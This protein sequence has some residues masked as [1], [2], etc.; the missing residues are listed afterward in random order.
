[1]ERR[2]PPQTEEG[3]YAL[4]DFRRIDWDAWRSVPDRTRERTLRTGIEYRR[5][6]ADPPEGSSGTFSINGH[7]ADLLFADLR[8][9]LADLNAVERGFE[10]TDFAEFTE[11]TTSYVSVT[12]ASG[13]NVDL[14][15]VL[16]GE[17]DSGLSQ[18]IQSRLEPSIPDAE[19]VSFYPMDKR[20]DPDQNWYDLSFEERSE[21]MSAHGDIGREYAGKVTQIITSSIGFDDWEWGVTL[22]ANDPAEIK[23]LLYEMRFDPSSAQFVDFGPFYVGQQIPPSDLRPLLAGEPVPSGRDDSADNA[24]G[25]SA[26]DSAATAPVVGEDGP[27][28]ADADADGDEYANEDDESGI[29]GELEGLGVYAGQPRG[30]DIYAVVVYSETHAD[31]L[32]EEMRG[33]RANFNHYDTHR[34][35]AVYEADNLNAVV[36]IWETESAADTAGGFLSDLPGVVR[37]AGDRIDED[38]WGTMG[39]FYTVDPD[40][41]DDFVGKFDEVT[42]VLEGMDGHVETDLL[43]NRE[44]EHD[45][46]IASRWDSKEDAMAFFRSEEFSDAVEWGRDVLVERPRHVFLA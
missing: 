42:D 15:A 12:E 6:A 20:R 22:F 11:R 21:H 1:M 4:Y 33:L 5:E 41:L 40:H 13:Y 16:E 29:R 24:G 43:G 23:K 35:T 44:Q 17:A 3:W 19:Y 30:E 37:Q 8:P 34:K 9:E 39:M 38:T 7:K 31:E 32:F 25:E 18:Y 14:E 27:D 10:R 26:P 46:F 36:S 2:E 28:D 45:M